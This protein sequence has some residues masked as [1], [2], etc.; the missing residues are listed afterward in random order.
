M[1]IRMMGVETR[2]LS[3]VYVHAKIKRREKEKRRYSKQHMISGK[4]SPL[5]QHDRD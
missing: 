2:P 1:L 5:G 3:H 4:S